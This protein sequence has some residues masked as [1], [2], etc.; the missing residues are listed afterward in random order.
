VKQGCRHI[1]LPVLS[2][3]SVFFGCS[4]DSAVRCTWRAIRTFLVRRYIDDDEGSLE[5][6]SIVIPDNAIAGEQTIDIAYLF[7]EIFPEIR[8]R[9]P[10]RSRLTR[11][12]ER[13][14]DTE[15]QFT[16]G[17]PPEPPREHTPEFDPATVV[18]GRRNCLAVLIPRNDNQD[19]RQCRNR[20]AASAPRETVLCTRHQNNAWNGYTRERDG[21]G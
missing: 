21:S 8:S 11:P 16:L 5:R 2:W 13:V 19:A 17:P 15:N 1:A 14:P 10:I 3:W 7:H 18:P 20:I 4:H 6:I 9:R 12:L